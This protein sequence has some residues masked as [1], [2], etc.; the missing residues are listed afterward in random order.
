MGERRVLPPPSAGEGTLRSRGGEGGASA[1][2]LLRPG[3]DL[4]GF[5]DAARRLVA[6]K[7][8]PEAVTWSVE[9]APSLFGSAPQPSTDAPLILPRR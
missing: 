3:A 6:Q 5:R 2:I 9:T 7:V 8:P 4:S 1:T